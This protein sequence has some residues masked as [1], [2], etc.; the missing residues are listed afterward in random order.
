MNKLDKLMKVQD[1]IILLTKHNITLSVEYDKDRDQIFYNLNTEA[2][3]HL[4]LYDDGTL[5]GRY[6]YETVL[7]LNRDLEDLIT[8]LCLEFK[9]CLH[10]RNYYNSFWKEF[11]NTRGFEIT[12]YDACL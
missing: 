8:E 2:K 7:D 9:K 3:S 6:K 5:R 12:R 1:I 10:G 4:Y 11:I